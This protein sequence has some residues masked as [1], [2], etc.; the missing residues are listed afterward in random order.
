MKSIGTNQNGEHV[1]EV[2]FEWSVRVKLGKKPK[3]NNFENLVK[4]KKAP[5]KRSFFLS[6]R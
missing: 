6:I 1:S 4:T 5:F 3:T 2:D